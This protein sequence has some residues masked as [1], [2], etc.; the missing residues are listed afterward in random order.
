VSDVPIRATGTSGHSAVVSTSRLGGS[1]EAPDSSRRT[2]PL[3]TIDRDDTLRR[4]FEHAPTGIALLD[5]DGRFVSVNRAFCR[6]L[7]YAAD[8]LV[9][10]FAQDMTH[11]PDIDVGTDLTMQVVRGELDVAR[12]SHRYLRKD[13]RVVH[14]VKHLSLLRDDGG[15]PPQFIVHF[16]DVTTEEQATQALEVSERRFRAL[17]MQVPVGIFETDASGHCT[18][19]NPRWQTLTGLSFEEA[20]GKGWTWA[21]HPADRERVTTLWYRAAPSGSE[22]S[23]E[24]RFVSTDGTMSWVQATAVPLRSEAGSV[25]GHIGTIFDMTDR[26]HAEVTLRR[27]LDEKQALLQEIHH[28]VKNNLQVISS[29]LRLQSRRAPQGEARAALDDS[30]ARVRSIALLHE[31]LYRSEDLARVD[32]GA[33]VRELVANLLRTHATEGRPSVDVSC[34]DLY[35]DI[36][37]AMPCGLVVNELVTNALKH[38]FVGRAPGHIGV[39]AKSVDESI[40]LVVED[41]GVGIQT[42]AADD[43]SPSTLGLS[44]V[45]SLAKQL[46]AELHLES[47]PGTR[48][49]LRFPVATS[50]GGQR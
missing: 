10:L 26:H 17:S 49:R 16:E 19:V 20:L 4:A 28:R 29:L 11:P 42:I 14:L 24:F 44:L 18:F 39:R 48:Y 7:G 2:A 50:A 13:G 3:A 1:G 30:E 22:F 6:I 36:A 31:S 32:F 35:V 8:E 37:I 5:L 45:H 38:A 40:E 12:I 41:D 34:A 46:D 23:A 9:G 47:S 27:S 25:V 43:P 33:Y 15:Q 21:V